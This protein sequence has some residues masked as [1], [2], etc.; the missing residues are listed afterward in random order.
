MNAANNDLYYTLEPYTNISGKDSSHMQTAKIP[1]VKGKL[2]GKHTVCHDEL[3][4]Y[5]AHTWYCHRGSLLCLN[6][7]IV[8]I[9]L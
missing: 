7:H 1:N 4:Y 9:C 5:S 3:S 6:C 2:M 8:N